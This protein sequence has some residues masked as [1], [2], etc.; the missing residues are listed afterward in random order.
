MVPHGVLEAIPD[1]A[2][3][4]FP[5][6]YTSVPLGVYAMALLNL[7]QIEEALRSAEQSLKYNPD[8]PNIEET[9]NACR[10]V[11][12]KKDAA[13][14]FV[15]LAARLK[16]L[17]EVKK[18]PIL[19]QAVPFDIAENPMV[20]KVKF[21]HLKPKT[22]AEDEVAIFCPATVEE[23]SPKAV[24]TK[25]IG[26]SETAVIELAKRWQKMGWQVTVYNWCSAE[27]GEYDGVRYRNYWEW[28]WQDDFNI[29][30]VWRAP[31]MFGLDIRARKKFLDLHDTMNPA[32]FTPNRLSRIDKIFVKTRAHRGLYPEIPDAKFA[33]VNNGIDLSRFEMKSPTERNPKKVIY[34]SS[35][36]RGLDILLK[37]WPKVREQI[38]DA[39]LHIYYGWKT[40]YEIEKGNPE[41]MIWM[42][43]VQAAAK[44]PG[45]VDHGR[46]S[47]RELALEF[48]GAGVWA[49]PTYFYEIS[50]ITAME[51]QAA[52]VIP[53][54]IN[55]A[56][57]RETVRHGVKID[58]DAWNE[59]VQQAWTE[60]LV[61]LLQNEKWQDEIRKAMIPDAFATFSWDEVAKAW[62][63]E[64]RS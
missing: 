40:F 34:S 30:V 59:G 25:G 38:P 46:M 39:E 55:Y 2:V 12:K 44:Q 3:T 45:V 16:E 28:N 60:R 19:L 31:E 49:Y 54:V 56:A 63:R 33:I 18:I 24:G 23:W 8:D 29:L 37:L 58:G 51:A 36:N 15:K 6:Q 41:R 48:L 14:N 27:D 47:Q 4:F 52:G 17:G 43:K 42:K 11:L 53:C 50:C 9:R 13:K 21:D 26:G 1:S 61:E 5:F 64:F 57:L 20:L 35:P 62:D 10:F 7:G 32:D 22:W